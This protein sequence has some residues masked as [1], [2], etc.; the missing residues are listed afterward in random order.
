MAA[1]KVTVV[2]VRAAAPAEKELLRIFDKWESESLSNIEGGARQI[3]QLVSALLGV[4]LAALALGDEKFAAALQA[5]LPIA[6]AAL[7]LLAW[8]AALLAALAVVIPGSHLLRRASL[9]D[10]RTVYQTL[11][12]Q[13]SLR[14]NVAVVAFGAGIVAFGALVFTLLFTR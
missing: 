12:A 13:K 7:T 6:L 1:K 3:I 11:L 2:G 9:D 14:M 10:M 4:M 8:L 5:P